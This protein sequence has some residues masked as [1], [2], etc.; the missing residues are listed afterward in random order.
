MPLKIVSVDVGKSKESRDEGMLP[1]GGEG[2]S[3]KSKGDTEK[4]GLME[5]AHIVSEEGV[6]N[7]VLPGRSGIVLFGFGRLMAEPM[8]SREADPEK[9]ETPT[10]EKIQHYLNRTNA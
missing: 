1:D 10:T 3:L 6:C 2:G 4:E 8:M 9:T 5:E 7:G